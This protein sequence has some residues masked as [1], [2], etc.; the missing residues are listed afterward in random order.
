[1]NTQDIMS[2][3]EAQGTFREVM[4][5]PLSMPNGD[6]VPNKKALVHTD[7][8]SYISTVG[9]NYRVIQ[10]EEVFSKLASSMAESTLD[11]DGFTVSRTS[12]TTNARSLVSIVLPA[13]QIETR[14]GDMTNLQLLTRNSYDGTWKFQVD[15][16]GFRIACANG[17]IYGDFVNAYAN[18]HTNG[19]TFD[20]MLEHLL[21]S[22]DTFATM[23][24]RW[25]EMKGMKVTKDQAIDMLMDYMGKTLKDREAR[26][27]LLESKRA[28][29]VHDMMDL[30][31]K[32]TKE[33]GSNMF[34]MYNVMTDHA[35]HV[36]D[37][38]SV[39]DAQ[40]Y[41]QKQVVKTLA[42]WEPRLAA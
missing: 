21:N 22:A 11:L 18:R 15:V 8:A 1:M 37:A 19:F 41:R 13:H 20:G 16:G 39:A 36:G 17:Q 9:K 40:N 28:T 7:D 35:S 34:A 24:H 38:T 27:K 31:V 5:V 25:M 26:D 32:Y 10:N 3:F 29:A 42:K 23:G 14:K 6:V 33:M 4:A 2:S 12:S 30:R